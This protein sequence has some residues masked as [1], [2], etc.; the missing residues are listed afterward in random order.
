MESLESIKL[1][2]WNRSFF[3]VN[4]KKLFVYNDLLLKSHLKKLKKVRNIIKPKPKVISYLL[5]TSDSSPQN[6]SNFGTSSF[7]SPTRNDYY[8]FKS[9]PNHTNCTFYDKSYKIIDK[10]IPNVKFIKP[11]RRIIKEDPNKYWSYY[12]NEP[13]K[14]YSSLISNNAIRFH[15][16]ISRREIFWSL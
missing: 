13:E 15:K 2:K 9:K 16:Q 11:K 3:V 10:N 12:K 8:L 6:L 1:G 4:S 5:S 14:N 7:K